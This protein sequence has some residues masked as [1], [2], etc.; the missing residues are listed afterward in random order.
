MPFLRNLSLFR[1]RPDH[2]MIS[3]PKSGRTWLR[4]MLDKLEIALDYS[5]AG[6]GHVSALH[7]SKLNNKERRK[8][9]KI[10]FLHRDPRDTAVSGYHQT[11]SRLKGYDASISDFIRDPHHGVEKIDHFNRLWIETAANDPDILVVSYEQLKADTDA[12]LAQI[13]TFLE[14]D[15]APDVI[16]KAVAE[17]AFEKM[18]A[19]EKSGFYKKQYGKVLTQISSDD[20]NSAKVRKGKVGGYKDELSAQDIAYCFL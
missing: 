12:C 4:V 3:F 13:C 20:P 2:A 17:G 19:R 16:A 15:R 14:Q 9:R 8:Y 10:V 7:L 6:S 11:N 5:H 1:R 18:Q